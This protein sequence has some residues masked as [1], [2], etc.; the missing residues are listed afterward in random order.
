MKKVGLLPVATDVVLFY[1][2]QLTRSF[3]IM[4]LTTIDPVKPRPS[5]KHYDSLPPTAALAGLM[6]TTEFSVLVVHVMLTTVTDRLAKQQQ[7][8][9][10]GG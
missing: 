8:S 6:F 7:V 5:N 4:A 10:N 1:N 9:A 2:T 3:C